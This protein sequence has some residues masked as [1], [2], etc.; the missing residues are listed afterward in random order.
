[1]KQ[2]LNTMF[3][4]NNGPSFHLW[5]KENLVKHG[6]VSNIM[7]LIARVTGYF[8]HY[9]RVT[10]YYVLQELRVTFYIRVTSY[11]LLRGL[12][13]NFTHE[14]LVII[15]CTSF[16]LNLSYKLQFAIYRQSWHCNVYCVT[17]LCYT[18]YS[19]LWPALYK[20]KYSSQLFLRNVFHEWVLQY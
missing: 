6:K 18:Y 2:L 14:L 16:K 9:I 11:Y 5:W 12:P 10:S 8:L 15:Y 7:K 13:V 17:F 20:T 1:M 3:I 19:F 4:S